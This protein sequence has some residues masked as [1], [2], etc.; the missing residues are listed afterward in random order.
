M[1]EIWKDVMG[2]EGIYSI[3][4]LNK[5]KNNNTNQIL[6]PIITNS[7][8]QYRLYKNKI[9][10]IYI[11]KNYNFNKINIIKN[12]ENENWKDIP[13]YEESYQISNLGRIKSKIRIGKFGQLYPEKILK[14]IKSNKGYYR[15]NLYKNKQGKKHLIHRLIAKVFIPNINNYPQINH[16]NGVKTDNR[17]ENLE[18]CTQKQNS[19]HASNLGLLNC[20]IKS[21]LSKLKDKNIPIIRNLYYNKKWKIR[22]IAK[23]FS[24]HDYTIRL[25]V[26]YRTWKHIK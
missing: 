20:G 25:I 3:S 18:W 2:Y 14:F 8:L 10:T 12:L 6:K 19:Q 17:I 24:V 16:K 13:N 15:I 11:I 4:N 23:Y 5:I 26:D 9:K 1:E 22:Q 7:S 21:N